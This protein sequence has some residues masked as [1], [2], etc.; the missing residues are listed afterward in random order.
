MNEHRKSNY[1]CREE[2]ECL[3]C[4]HRRID[5]SDPN[6]IPKYIDPLPIPELAEHA[7][8]DERDEGYRISMTETFHKFHSYFPKTKVWGYNGK[9]PGPTIEAFRDRTTYIKWEN[10]LPEKHLLPYDYTL[11]GTID[12][13][14]VKTV[15]HLHGAHV[16]PESDGYP[17][18]WFTRNY[19]LT[20]PSF[21]K[22]VYKYTNHQRA[23]T[24]WYHDHA[25]GA[26]R[27]NVYAGL[28]GFYLIRDELE[29]RLNLPEG[30]YEIPLMI[31]DKTFNSDGSLFYPEPVITP[32]AP[33][34]GFI[35]NTIS[36]N[37]KLWPHL[38]VEPRKY[39]LR[40]LNGSNERHYNLQ[41]SNKAS[42][43]QIGTD[44][45]FLP[46]PNEIK[47]FNLYPAERMDVIVDFSKYR[48]E[49]ITLTNSADDA[50]SNTKVIM[51]FRVSTRLSKKDT[52]TIPTIL[53][54]YDHID[55]KNAAKIRDLRLGTKLDPYGRLML[56]LNGHMFHDPVTEIVQKDSVEVWNI[57]NAGPV[58]HPIHIHLVQFK[59]LSRTS[60]TTG[61]DIP[62]NSYELGFKDTI[63]VPSG[64]ITT[65]AMQFSGF[66]GEYVWHC[67][68][69]EHEDHDM[70]RPLRVTE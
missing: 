17:E 9:Y 23:T 44:G 15:V 41:L 63:A 43:Y 25:M 62:I 66:S 10:H 14:E 54:P 55:V 21:T 51:K 42:F 11:H 1:S 39:R 45:G 5:P 6:T 53:N 52:S 32:G 22:K 18:A 70:M 38:K 57:I 27:L 20:G 2:S 26:T 46:Q 56:L 34:P 36:V 3:N 4:R 59:I 61:E 47:S 49:S 33:I 16:E 28:A 64:T 68:F 19:A 24:L 37:G 31:Q 7:F 30:K 60:I 13:P 29:E 69:L 65:V 50:D 35:G 67:H 8:N 12:S 48:G 58:T 40:F